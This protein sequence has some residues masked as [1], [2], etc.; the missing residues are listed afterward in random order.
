MK[1]KKK[2]VLILLTLMFILM[3]S[4]F[5]MVSARTEN[6]WFG[7]EL[8]RESGNG[9]IVNGKNVWEICSYGTGTTP[10]AVADH[11]ETK[12]QQNIYLYYQ[13]VKHTKKCYG[14]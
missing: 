9:Y 1:L 12:Y 8:L 3:T 13:K 7:L 2:N 5:S 10:S 14:Y 11:S 6:K 4:M